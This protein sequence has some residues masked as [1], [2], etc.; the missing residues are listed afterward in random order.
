MVSGSIYRVGQNLVC[1]VDVVGDT[2]SS[3]V[4]RQALQNFKDFVNVIVLGVAKLCNNLERPE[5][6]SSKQFALLFASEVLERDENGGRLPRP[7]A[8]GD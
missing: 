2:S 6:L 4:V 1:E 7:V 8:S 3:Q 5:K